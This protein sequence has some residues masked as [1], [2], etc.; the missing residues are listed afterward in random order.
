MHLRFTMLRKVDTGI[1]MRSI[2]ILLLTL[3]SLSVS[4]ADTSKDLLAKLFADSGVSGSLIIESVEGDRVFSHNLSDDERYLPASTFKIPNTLIVLEEGLITDP[5]ATIK[6]D[7][8]ARSYAPW[9]KDQT[10][11]SAFQFS[12]VWCYQRYAA[13]VGDSKYRAYLHKL[14]YGNQQTGPDVQRFWLDGDLSISVKEQIDF[15]R[16]VYLETLPVSQAHIKTL[17]TIMLSEEQAGYRVWSKT[18][19]AGKDG[20][21]VGYLTVGDQTWLFANH[22]EINNRAELKYRKQLVMDA[23]RNLKLLER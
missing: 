16:N 7:G 2:Q 6:W 9:N 15:I 21:Y 14:G 11:K 19:W 20:W 18:G 4:A 22:I 12:C 17:K 8:V 23:F 10:L 5:A 3:V 13:Q 1:P